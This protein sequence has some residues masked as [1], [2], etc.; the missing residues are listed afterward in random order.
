MS[1]NTKKF[2]FAAV[3]A[4]IFLGGLKLLDKLRKREKQKE[5]SEAEIVPVVATS[6]SEDENKKTVKTESSTIDNPFTSAEKIDYYKIASGYLDE[7]DTAD[8]RTSVAIPEDAPYIISSFEFGEKEG[9][10]QNNLLYFSDGYLTDERGEPVDDIPKLVGYESLDRF[11]EDA[12]CDAVYV[13]NDSIK[14]DFEIIRRED[15]YRKLIRNR[16]PGD[17]GGGKS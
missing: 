6:E 16:K 17:A 14:Y 7:T 1:D 3:G 9:Y 2:I 15:S 5:K 8:K 10:N 13:R 11:S 4:A 12:S